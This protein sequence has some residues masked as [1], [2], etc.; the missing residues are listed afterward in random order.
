M[1]LVTDRVIENLEYL[2]RLSKQPSEPQLQHAAPR[3]C[4]RDCESKRVMLRRKDQHRKGHLL[5]ASSD[6][7]RERDTM[8][9]RVNGAVGRLKSLVCLCI[10]GGLRSPHSR[11]RV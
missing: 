10:G 9:Q 11:A 1:A 2:S 7:E 5:D 4:R 3:G 8:R 6:S